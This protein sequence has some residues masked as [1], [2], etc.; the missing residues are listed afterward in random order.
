MSTRRFFTCPKCFTK[1]EIT[2]IPIGQPVQCPNC[3]T[4]VVLKPPEKDP[5]IGSVIG[6]CKIWSEIGRGGMGS[7]YKAQHIALNKT[8]AV[9]ILAPEL[10]KNQDYVKR[11]IREA[12]AAAQIEHHNVVQV[13]NVGQEKGLYFIVMHYVEGESARERLKRGGFEPSE[14]LDVILQC[15]RGIKA[16]EAKGIVHRDIKPDNILIT[17]DGVAKIADF[18]LARPVI[19]SALTS[20]NRVIGTPYYMSPEQAEGGV[21]DIRSDIYSLG[22][23]FYHLVTGQPPFDAPTPIAIFVK[24]KQEAPIPPSQIAKGLSVE[25]DIIILKM[26]AK[27]PSDRY[28]NVQSLIDDLENLKAGRPVASTDQIQTLLVVKDDLPAK[29][30]SSDGLL[31]EDDY[32]QPV[33]VAR[34]PR[35]ADV[36]APSHVGRQIGSTIFWL[37]VLGLI[38]GAAWWV[39]KKNEA[40]PPPPPQ[41]HVETK[42]E[43]E[44]RAAYEKVEQFVAQN[45]NA[46]VEII[47]QYEEL[48]RKCAGTVYAE[49]ARTSAAFFRQRRE[50]EADAALKKLV[51]DLD[52][53]V[54]N[55]QFRP[56]LAKLEQFRQDYRDVASV[57]QKAPSDDTILERAR[58]KAG[59]L[60]EDFEA[61][62]DKQKV[63]QAEKLLARIEGWQLDAVAPQARKLAELIDLRKKGALLAEYGSFLTTI[64]Q[65]LSKW[66]FTRALS[67]ARD[68]AARPL[69][70][71]LKPLVEKRL[72]DIEIVS[73]GFDAMLVALSSKKG[74]EL[75]IPA[76]VAGATIGV[77]LV[78]ADA[79]GITWSM[80]SKKT[81]LRWESL[82]PLEILAV[83]EL[84]L[85]K[86]APRDM[87]FSGLLLFELGLSAE[88]LQRFQLAASLD[89]SLRDFVNDYLVRD[90]GR[91]AYVPEGNF[92]M[93][94]DT[95]NA[96]EQPASVRSL[97]GFLIDKFEVSNAEYS[98]YL[99]I[100]K[101]APPKDW[102]DA[103]YPSGKG[104]LPVAG[105]TLQAA[106]DFAKWAHKRLPS[107]EEW[108]KACRGTDSR[109]YPWGYQFEQDRVNIKGDKKSAGPLAVYKLPAG[110]SPYGCLH[111]LGNV[112]EWTNSEYK[113]YPR[114]PS[115]I[116]VP[117]GLFVVRGGSYLTEKKN[118]RASI[119]FPTHHATSSNDIGFRCARGPAELF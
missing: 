94:L 45:P 13:L 106:R 29:A 50:Q 59:K 37:F 9:K 4:A 23:T 69:A 61:G 79:S 67:D 5:L 7:V 14:A 72:K 15:A 17:S 108:E 68:A 76:K 32:N 65:S 113:P 11:F 36:A 2:N 55:E 82:S 48:V 71:P 84:S 70:D 52:G 41:Q 53:L 114:C 78:S 40:E 19:D 97:A 93:G 58:Q 104:D 98:R 30:A 117:P 87:L 3:G 103:N 27:K 63:E 77:R 88:A 38:V 54:A 90:P 64:A 60:V 21:V 101:A 66:D 28:Q 49:K 33:Q 81:T 112:S 35:A 102:P 105:V 115:V 96:D 24:H 100:S 116:Q 73:A 44:A 57:V 12:R 89:P 34:R 42:Q 75:T 95:G 25:Y 92:E 110:A 119:R 43:K 91:A 20:Q 85:D 83:F 86:K 1:N 22:A 109:L 18:G 6:G 31:V 10:A 8:V 39:V 107:E 111:M 99:A 80:A 46:T 47:G 118:C 62:S 74:Q 26:M 56:A 16:A 51:S